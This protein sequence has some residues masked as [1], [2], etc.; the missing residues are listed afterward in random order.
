[1]GGLMGLGVGMSFISVIEFFYFICLRK[2]LHILRASREIR[3]NNSLKGQTDPAS[4]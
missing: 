2:Y 1:M 4:N 3:R